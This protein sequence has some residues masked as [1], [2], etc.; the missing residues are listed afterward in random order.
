[1]CHPTPPIIRAELG[2]LYYEISSSS[3]PVTMTALRSIVPS[4]H[5]LLG[6]DSPFGPMSA[7][8]DQLLKLDLP[9]AELIGIE[10]QNALTLMPQLQQFLI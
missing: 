2:K 1:M 9:P 3:D 4:S 10:R 5:I 6:T 7:T 8:I